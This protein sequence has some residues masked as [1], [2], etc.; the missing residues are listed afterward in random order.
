MH[1]F[2][3]QFPRL[4]HRLETPVAPATQA[5]IQARLDARTAAANEVAQIAVAEA[6]EVE[7]VEVLA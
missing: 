7:P 1:P 6:V 2:G 4:G 3:R 5:E